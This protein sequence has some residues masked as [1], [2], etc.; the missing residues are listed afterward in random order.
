MNVIW[1]KYKCSKND[2]IIY[3]WW[4]ILHDVD[5]GPPLYLEQ[6]SISLEQLLI[7]LIVIQLWYLSIMH[8]KIIAIY[9]AI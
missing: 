7:Y 9:Y 8:Y 1:Y 6:N 2:N 5:L 4:I 3:I